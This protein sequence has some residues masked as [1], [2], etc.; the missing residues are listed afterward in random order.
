MLYTSESSLVNIGFWKFGLLILGFTQLLLPIGIDLNWAFPPAL[1]LLLGFEF[2]QGFADIS[3]RHMFQ[4]KRTTFFKWFVIPYVLFL[5]LSLLLCKLWDI[6]SGD[7]FWLLFLC[8]NFILGYN[9]QTINFPEFANHT[10]LIAVSFQLF[11]IFKVSSSL[12]KNNY[13]KALLVS[14]I[15]F[16][17]FF[18]VASIVQGMNELQLY[19]NPLSHVDSFGC[20][21]LVAIYYRSN[22]IKQMVYYLS[23]A[24][25]IYMS[26][27]ITMVYSLEIEFNQLLDIRPGTFLWLLAHQS[28]ISVS[29]LFISLIFFKKIHRK[30]V[31]PYRTIIAFAVPYTFV[32]Y[33]YF[34]SAKSLIYHALSLGSFTS[35]Q[36]LSTRV[37]ILLSGVLT[38]A[39]CLMVHFACRALLHRSQSKYFEHNVKSIIE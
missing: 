21:C 23:K 5:L 32:L 31:L 28:G 1:F 34:P 33:L 13:R 10:W 8:Q 17:S 26:F 3:F 25:L 29:T 7:G 6:P 9:N 16:S 24:A 22:Y 18:K 12:T 30:F 14:L 39:S 20:G 37:L 11:L 27:L 36:S 38:L 19:Y 4:F 2:E 35:N 15:I